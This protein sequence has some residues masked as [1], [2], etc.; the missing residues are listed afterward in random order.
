MKHKHHII[1]KHM[2]GTDDPGNLISLTPEEHAEAHR[3]L[4]ENYGKIED[5]L[6]WKGLSGFIGK[7]D[8]IK[9]LMRE[10]GKRLGKRMLEEKKGIFDE[11]K[12]KSEKYKGGIRKGGE[13]TGKMM[14][15]SGHCKKIAPLGGGKNKGKKYWF[16]EKENRETVSEESPGEGWVLGVN[17]SRIN[18]DSLRENCRNR[19]G[20]FWITNEETGESKMIPKGEEIPKGF[21]EG[22]KIK[23]KNIIEIHNTSDEKPME[24]IPS[25]RIKN[26]NIIFNQGNLRWEFIKKGKNKIKVSHTD[27]YGLFWFRDCFINFY[28]LPEENSKFNFKCVSL[29][30]ALKILRHWREYHLVSG[31]LENEKLKKSRREFYG[32]KLLS[33]KINYDYLEERRKRII[34]EDT[35]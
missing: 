1:P 25:I 24:G 19:E 10:N 2:G 35:L 29:E 23:R 26:K 31:I 13:T 6:A 33:L 21:T 15:D 22:R 18:L 3:I 4:Y 17:Y 8:I 9:E 5:Y 30:E 20:T 34:I 7:E 12:K 16:N 28:G 27:Y 14:A 11:E 32:K